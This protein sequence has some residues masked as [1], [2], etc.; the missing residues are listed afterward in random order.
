MKNVVVAFTLTLALTA[1]AATKKS[2][3]AAIKPAET[4]YSLERANAIRLMRENFERVQFDLDSASVTEISRDAL[5]ANVELMRRFPDIYLE[6]EGHCDEQG[7]AEY[8][9]TLGQL[10]ADA[11]KKYMVVSGIAGRRIATISYGEEIPV[12]FDAAESAYALNRRAE[13]LIVVKQT[14]GVFGSVADAGALD[15]V[16][17]LH[18]AEPVAVQVVELQFGDEQVALAGE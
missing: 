9:L 11:I 16:D 10:R 2:P 1:C 14:E 6:V 13:F 4:V 18:E 3:E 7:S 15:R 17:P 8:N 12:A 5:S